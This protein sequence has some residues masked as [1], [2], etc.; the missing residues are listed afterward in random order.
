MYKLLFEFLLSVLLCLQLEMELLDHMI[1]LRFIYLLEWQNGRKR[2][3]LLSA[4]L[5]PKSM[6]Q[7]GLEQAKGKSQKFHQGL[8]CR[9]QESKYLDQ[10]AASEVDVELHPRHSNSDISRDGFIPSVY[11]NMRFPGFQL[12]CS[13]A[14]L[15]GLPI[16]ISPFWLMIYFL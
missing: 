15:M 10:E 4:G 11:T 14:V 12:A 13:I 8:P 7:L 3:K 16:L 5:Y 1:I 9:W 2:E 6:Q